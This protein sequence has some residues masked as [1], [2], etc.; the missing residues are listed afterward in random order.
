MLSVTSNAGRASYPFTVSFYP[1]ETGQVLVNPYMGWAPWADQGPY[2]QPHSLVYINA[3]WRELEP[4]KGFYRFDLLEQENKFDYWSSKNVKII[5]RIHMDYPRQWRHMDIPDWLYNETGRDGT[6][7]NVPY[8]MGYSPNYNNK[9]LIKYHDLLIKA[10][11]EKYNTDGRIAFIALGSLGHWGEFHTWKSNSY[12]IPFPRTSAS[13]QYVGQYVKYFT[14]KMLLMRRPFAIA[15]SN[16]MGLFNDSF[17][18][19][20][21]TV[22][23]FLDYITDGYKDSLTGQQHPPMPDFWKHAPSGGEFANYPGLQYLNDSRIERTLEMAR[24]THLSWLGPSAP[25]YGDYGGEIR[26]NSDLLLK[27]MGYRFVLMILTVHGDT[28]YSGDSL[29]IDM[30]WANKGA[31][32]FYFNWP[33]ELSI[34][35]PDGNPM[36]VKTLDTNIRTWLPGE[37]VDLTGIRLDLPSDAVNG[38]YSVRVAIIDP[39]TGAPAIDFPIKGEMADGTYEMGKIYISNGRLAAKSYIG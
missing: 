21:Q 19:E 37:K 30:S 36:M 20:R 2:T 6:W 31:A 23:S 29:T 16:N 15:K 27:T 32:P 10:L 38:T 24:E 8:G 26:T 33:V 4:A 13:D 22:S 39:A 7:Y 1:E 3:S 34:V 14:D 17:G 12:E 28:F 25:I 35:G 5:L 18:D 11:A 9:T